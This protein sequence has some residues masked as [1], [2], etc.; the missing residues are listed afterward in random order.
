MTG[1]KI[2]DLEGGSIFCLGKWKIYTPK[3]SQ[4]AHYR[5]FYGSEE[6]KYITSL[7]LDIDAGQL[8]TI[9]FQVL[10]TSEDT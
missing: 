7:R 6:I 2:R 5:V 1:L 9:T 4:P 8:A 3:P 10:I